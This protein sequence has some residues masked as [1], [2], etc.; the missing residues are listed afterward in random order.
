MAVKWPLADGNWSNAANWNSGTKPVAGD[1][2]YADGKII[3]IDETPVCASIRNTTRS[4]GINYGRFTTSVSMTIT[5]DLYSLTHG[6][7][8]TNTLTITGSASVTLIGN[9]SHTTGG[10]NDTCYAI[11]W[12]SSGT[13]SITG[14]LSASSNRSSGGC[15]NI[16]GTGAVSIVG[17]LAQVSNGYIINVSSGAPL[18]VTGNLTVAGSG[19]GIFCSAGNTIII[20]GNLLANG[21]ACV[22]NASWASLLTVTGNVVAGTSHAIYNTAVVSLTTINGNMVNN[23]AIVAVCAIRM[24]IQ[25]TQPTFWTFYTVAGVDRT[26]YSADSLPGVPTAANVRLGTTYGPVSELTGTLAVPPAGS[27]ALGVPVDATVGTAAI[28]Q[29]AIAD[30]VGPLIAAFGS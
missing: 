26:L 9:V 20:T 30:A 18:T 25:N 16:T 12:D 3:T 4:G 1:D 10:A 28:T 7:S 24:R 23:G 8:N 15:I 17:T 5:A 27:V 19:T 13:L 2:V 22:S 21:G 6:A 11:R 14:S 29:Q